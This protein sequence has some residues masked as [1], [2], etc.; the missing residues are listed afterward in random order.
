MSRLRANRAIADGSRRNGPP[1]RQ[2]CREL[3]RQSRQRFGSVQSSGAAH[4]GTAAALSAD[5]ETAFVGG[6]QDADGAGAIWQFARLPAPTGRL[7]SARRTP[8]GPRHP[9]LRVASLWRARGHGSG[10]P[11]EARQILGFQ[12]AYV[13]LRWKRPRAEDA[14]GRLPYVTN[15]G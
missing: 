13:F 1:Y 14:E 7:E 11:N 10:R 3:R 12:L 6:A 5:G 8:P 15:W 2:R 4:F 9:M